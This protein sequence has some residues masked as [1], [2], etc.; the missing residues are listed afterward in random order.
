MGIVDEDIEKVR[1][2]SDIVA[3]V[4]QHLALRKVGRRHMGLCPFHAEKS[5]SF[6]VNAEQGLYYCFGC[7][8][9]GDVITFVREVE[10]LDFVGAVEWLAGRTGIT[11]RYTDQAE[12]EGRKK[13]QKLLDAMAKATAWYHERLLSGPDAAAAR[14]YLRSRGMSGDEVRQFSIGWA[15]E[16][17]DALA[18]ALRLPNEVWVQSGL[19]FLNRNDRQTDAFRG[20]VLFPIM[21]VAGNPVAFGGRILPDGEGPKYKNSSESAIYAKSRTLYGLNWAKTAIVQADEAIVC[22]G[23]TDVIG[24]HAAGVPRAV[25]TC[26]TALTEEHLAALRR[27]ARRIVLAFDADSAGQSAA[28]RVYEWE[29]KH[30]LEIAV[31]ALPDGVDP[32][33]LARTDPDALAAAVQGATSFLGFRVGRVLGAADLASPERRVRAAEAAID[34]VREH[35][36]PLVRDQYVIEIADRCKVDPERLRTALAGPARRTEPPAK[37]RG[38]HDQYQ[39]QSRAPMARV[40]E[41]PELE[42]LRLAIH[43]PE[44]VAA[45]LEPSLF[46]DLRCLAAFRALAGSMTLHEAI[47]AA[48]PAAADLLARLAAEETDAEALDVVARLVQQAGARTLVDLERRARVGDDEA[49]ALASTIAAIKLGLEELRDHHEP[50]EVLDRLL[51]LLVQGDE[52]R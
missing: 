37:G 28:E 10:H 23:Y 34:V 46:D 5:G 44:E 19:G 11:L 47:A 22:E 42:A 40:R 8:A 25:A 27:F 30:D 12:G 41:S 18:K 52:E 49:L 35:P 36:S 45:W 15:P 17:W 2:A 26:G 32:G 50:A 38:K 39:S 33:D 31:A 48:D 51:G 1:E 16:G 9:K 20:R 21:D 14:S 13:K 7:G 4:S 6:S 3:I 29:R 24:F 43:R